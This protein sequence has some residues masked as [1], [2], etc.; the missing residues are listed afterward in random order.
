MSP[1]V[2]RLTSK[3]T[4]CLASPF[5]S[6]N[7]PSRCCLNTHLA[8]SPFAKTTTTLSRIWAKQQADFALTNPHNFPPTF[9][10][11]VWRRNQLHRLAPF[12]LD[13]LKVEQSPLHCFCSSVKTSQQGT[14][15]GLDAISILPRP[16]LLPVMPSALELPAA[17]PRHST[18][19][20]SDRS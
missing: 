17:A 8:S 6:P 7:P 19:A 11:I 5:R 13:K 14:P 15:F 10:N 16:R 18:S 9:L 4:T 3:T 2:R 20:P 12:W 1:V